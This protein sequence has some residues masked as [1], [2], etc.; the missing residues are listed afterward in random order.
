[1]LSCMAYARHYGFKTSLYGMPGTY[2][3]KDEDRSKTIDAISEARLMGKTYYF[4]GVVKKDLWIHK[5][6]DK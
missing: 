1:M 3:F 6:S 4:N 2:S 5:G